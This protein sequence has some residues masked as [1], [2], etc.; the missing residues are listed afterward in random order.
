MMLPW[1]PTGQAIRFLKRIP[2]TSAASVTLHFGMG[3][4][5]THSGNYSRPASQVLLPLGAQANFLNDKAVLL[6]LELKKEGLRNCS[7][8]DCNDKGTEVTAT[9]RRL[10]IQVSDLTKI[11]AKAN[12]LDENVT[13]SD[14]E[15]ILLARLNLPDLRLPRYDVP[16]T[17]PATS[18]EVY[19][20]FHSVFQTDKLVQNTS[21]ALT[22]AYAAF[23]PLL[24]KNYS[25]NPF[26]SFF[27]NFSFF[28]QFSNQCKRRFAFCNTIMTFLMTC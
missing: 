20:A 9:V 22:A 16:N 3:R 2:I 23:K 4:I 27:N 28:R 8:N 21:N 19:A 15:G 7:P 18:N 26:S 24:E 17:G 6:F 5:N 12:G 14:L 13:S 25:S 10:L 1:F 11:I